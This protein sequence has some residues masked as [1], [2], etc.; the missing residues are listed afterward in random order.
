MTKK[1][2]KKPKKRPS[3]LPLRV[4]RALAPLKRLRLK[5]KSFRWWV[6]WPIYIV[7]AIILLQAVSS[8]VDNVLMR[9]TKNPNY[10]VSFS[11]KYA[12]ELGLDWKANYL[13]L[14]KDLQFK[15]LRL[16][17]YWDMSE[18]TKGQYD[19]K[20]LD[21]QFEQANKNGVKVS[22]AIGFRQPRW[23]ECHEPEWAKQLPIESPQWRAALNNYTEV[24]VKR[25]KDNPALISYQ[26]ENEAKN[27]WFGEC[28]GASAPSDRLNAEFDLVKKLDPNHPTM[29]SLSDQ[30][31][32]PLGTP[33]P[34][35][36]G[37]S[38]YR[39]V[40][41][42]NT[43]IHFYV[44]YPTTI[45]YHRLRAAFVN[46]VK[47]RPVYIHELQMEPWGPSATK[48]L[49]IEEQNR[50]MSASQ[51]HKSVDYTRKTGIDDIYMWGGEWWYW[52][53]EKFNDPSIW[54]AVRDE[55]NA[56]TT[57]HTSK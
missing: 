19:F 37:F 52:R 15:N 41:S 36:Y 46:H 10:G 56:T 54:N 53:K 48:N 17:S 5:V 27:N 21:W 9:P 14:L 11:I 38:I 29:M 39:I 1:P 12:N 26:L 23:P 4:Q 34:D 13:A 51:I 45:W 47:D 43:P 49:T 25:Y 55:L 28:R 30:H 32:L 7:S 18:P 40:Y 33:V 6:R 20:D 8:F 22:L 44:T 35:A 42:T 3:R 31:G 2:T 16:M 57:L 24:V 50:S